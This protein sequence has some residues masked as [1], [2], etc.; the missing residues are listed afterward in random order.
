MREP[1]L[2]KK[3]KIACWLDLCCTSAGQVQFHHA[4]TLSKIFSQYGPVKEA[5]A[6]I[7]NNANSAQVIFKRRMDA[8]AAFAGAGK[9][10]ALGPAL[11]SFRLT[12]FPAAGLG[13]EPSHGASKGDKSKGDE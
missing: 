4:V 12:D 2:P 13:D 9:I 6:E 7:P 3:L 8:E 10:S 5:K 1:N 11:D